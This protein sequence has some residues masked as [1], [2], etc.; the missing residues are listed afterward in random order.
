MDVA[1]YVALDEWDI[2]YVPEDY[3]SFHLYS[4]KS[5]ITVDQSLLDRWELCMKEFNTLQSIFEGL[6]EAQK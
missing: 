6:R 4:K 1:I 2:V 3:D 5:K